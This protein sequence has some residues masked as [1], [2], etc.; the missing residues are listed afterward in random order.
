MEMSGQLHAMANLPVGQE[1][2]A[3]IVPKANLDAVVK[4]KIQSLP[5]PRNEP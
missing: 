2:L 3:S 1:P 4:M 5:P